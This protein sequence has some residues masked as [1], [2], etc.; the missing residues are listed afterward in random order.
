[1]NT[2][3]LLTLIVLMLSF[4][5]CNKTEA[6]ITGAPASINVVNAVAAEDKNDL[7]M[8]FTGNGTTYA[9]SKRLSYWNWDGMSSNGLLTFGVPSQ[10]VL[11][12][13]VT[14]AS[15]T[16]KPVFNQAIN[17]N[18]GDIYSLF[19]GGK[20]ES[21]ELC[22]AKGYN[23]SHLDSL[24]AVRFINMSQDLPAVSIN[25]AGQPNGSEVTRLDYKQIT[26]FKMYPARSTNFSY[27]FEIRDAAA[28]DVLTSFTYE[29]L[30]RF[31]HVTLVIRGLKDSWPGVEVV[32][33]N[34]W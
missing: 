24:T 20:L 29:K 21:I 30:A 11:P 31:K 6:D 34:N 7:N 5:S 32:R 22:S 9:T 18:P 26:G 19:I 14:L 33:V 23:T 13:I 17:F 12:L 1:M 27:D 3:K 8:N 28:D 2:N 25:L 16:T 15:D 10:Q 4:I